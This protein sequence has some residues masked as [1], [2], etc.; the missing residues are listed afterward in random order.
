[1]KTIEFFKKLKELGSIE[2]ILSEYP[3]LSSKDIDIFFDEVFQILSKKDNNN[4][5]LFTDGAAKGNPGDAGIGFVIKKEGTVI[6]SHSSYIGKTTNNVAEYTALIEGLKRLLS[7][8]I[9]NVNVF[10]DSELMVKQLNGE[11]SVKNEK[12]KTLY[13]EAVQLIKQFDKFKLS[14]IPRN[15]NKEADSL[16]KQGSLNHFT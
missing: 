15:Q 8:N 7:L 6:D 11:Y 12:L 1:M 3:D 16:S 14:H 13:N 10:S 9:K 4:Y 2:K 5:E